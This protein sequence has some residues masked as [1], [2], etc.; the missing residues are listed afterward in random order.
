M[1]SPLPGCA[2]PQQ[3]LP[4]LSGSLQL[5]HS[6]R[7]RESDAGARTLQLL[8]MKYLVDLG[9]SL[10]L[11]PEPAVA[12][13][14][15]VTQAVAG[16]VAG[17]GAGAVAGT[18]SQQPGPSSSSGSS[19]IRGPSGQQVVQG[20]ATL[21][22][23][24]T[25]LL[26]Q[27]LQ[28]ARVDMAA[29]SRHGLVHGSLLCLKYVVEVLPWSVLATSSCCVTL[30][31][32]AATAAASGLP[33]VSASASNTT[34]TSSSSSSSRS[35][36]P[37]SSSGTA[38]VGGGGLQGVGVVDVCDPA[39]AVLHCWVVELTGLLSEVAELVRPLLSAQVRELL[40]L[41]GFSFFIILRVQPPG[42]GSL[43]ARQSRT[44]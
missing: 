29:A 30:Q 25:H 22:G 44:P 28:S 24:L 11:A 3:L 38:T 8:V 14:G 16:A 33:T 2:T 31:V 39:P 43:P 13:A 5:L 9:W 21:L 20:A 17:A 6:P 4:L 42:T 40:A 23:S 18:E 41:R 37:G 19:S 35:S 7:V 36:Q 15:A 32:S 10:T 26:Q 1:P 27:Q 34:T 12:V